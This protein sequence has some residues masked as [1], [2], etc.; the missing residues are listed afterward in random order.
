MHL[1]FWCLPCRPS[2][3]R[4][5]SA[6]TRCGA[7]GWAWPGGPS[8]CVHRHLALAGKQCL[9]PG[10]PVCLLT[11]CPTPPHH[12]PT[13]HPAAYAPPRHPPYR[14]GSSAS[15]S[16][17]EVRGSAS[18]VVIVPQGALPARDGRTFL[19]PHQQHSPH[20]EHPPAAAA[21]AAE[22]CCPASVGS[23]RLNMPRL[24]TPLQRRTMTASLGTTPSATAKW[25][26]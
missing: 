6:S 12:G 13:P 20:Q 5:P 8:V 15:L 7:L 22:R 4:S 10:R 9:A 16:A 1:G 19:L 14:C 17:M 23:L 2:M 21:A 24:P 18:C 11:C 25:A 26:F 3:K